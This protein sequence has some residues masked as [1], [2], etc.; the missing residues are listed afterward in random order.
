MQNGNHQSVFRPSPPYLSVL[1][2][3]SLFVAFI[4][5]SETFVLPPDTPFV[6][7]PDTPP[8]VFPL[9]WMQVRTADNKHPDQVVRGAAG[10]IWIR[11]GDSVSRISHGTLSVPDI[12]LHEGVQSIASSQA[13]LYFGTRSGLFWLDELHGSGLAARLTES[14]VS[15]V[16]SSPNRLWFASTSPY[17]GS[18]TYWLQLDS[19]G[20]PHGPPFPAEYPGINR[21]RGVL[22][23]CDDRLIALD[24][25]QEVSVIPLS[26]NLGPKRPTVEVSL[27]ED[28]SALNAVCVGQ[29]AWLLTVT[30]HI[31]SPRCCHYDFQ[32]F[33]QIRGAAGWRRDSSGGIGYSSV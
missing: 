12:G 1:L 16:S 27:Y 4:S 26:G 19:Q 18:Q 22:T 30:G 25:D 32:G 2:A 5:L 13:G 15:W 7:P 20:R 24:G 29:L 23:A 31:I 21:I 11:A 14:R 8:G 9:G 28:E 10:D 33:L 6:L 3:L 17:A